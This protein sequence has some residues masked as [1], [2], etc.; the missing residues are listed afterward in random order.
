MARLLKMTPNV[1]IR[2]RAPATT[3]NPIEVAPNAWHKFTVE[4][5]KTVRVEAS[6][7]S[8]FIV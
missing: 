8:T 2:Q 4:S 5:G 7:H 1:R 3:I 6:G